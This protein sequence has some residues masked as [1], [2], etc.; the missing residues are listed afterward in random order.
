M[1][2]KGMVLGTTIIGILVA[3]KVFLY[4][5]IKI[6]IQKEKEKDIIDLNNYKAG[7]DYFKAK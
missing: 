6:E 7:R 4:T 2:I 5:Q 3:Y 1:D